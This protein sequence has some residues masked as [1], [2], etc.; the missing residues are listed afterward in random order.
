MRRVFRDGLVLG[1][2]GQAGYHD[3]LAA[4]R[5]KANAS[6]NKGNITSW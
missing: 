4:V 2:D 6:V 1:P 5:L 3:P